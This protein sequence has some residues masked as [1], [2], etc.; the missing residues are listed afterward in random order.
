[1]Y[2]EIDNFKHKNFTFS[3]DST[4]KLKMDNSTSYQEKFVS[5]M[6]LCDQKLFTGEEV[7]WYCTDTQQLHVEELSLWQLAANKNQAQ[8][9]T[10]D[11]KV[12]FK[13]TAYRLFTNNVNFMIRAGQNLEVFTGFKIFNSATDPVRIDAA[14]SAVINVQWDHAIKLISA[15]LIAITCLLV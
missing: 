7:H 1:M 14:D 13:I 2:M 11:G 3:E 10:V 5:K 15:S 8:N 12:Y 9:V 4:F 6:S